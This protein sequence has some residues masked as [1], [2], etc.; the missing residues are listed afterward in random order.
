MLSNLYSWKTEK[1]N[2]KK[3]AHTPHPLTQIA[4]KEKE[5]HVCAHLSTTLKAVGQTRRK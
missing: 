4:K 5:E 1:V 3:H 2:I